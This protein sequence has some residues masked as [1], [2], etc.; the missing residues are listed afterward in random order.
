MQVC[1]VTDNV[2]VTVPAS[3]LLFYILE[4]AVADYLSTSYDEY[5][6]N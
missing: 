1:I 6:P 3:S 5:L 4:V 2:I